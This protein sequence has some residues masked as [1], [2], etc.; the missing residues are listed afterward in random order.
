MVVHSFSLDVSKPGSQ[1]VIYATRGDVG[2]RRLVM[3]L[4]EDGAPVSLSAASSVVLRVAKPDDTF[5]LADCD[6]VDAEGG[7]VDHVLEASTLAALGRAA[8]QLTVYGVDSDVLFSP[9][10]EIFVQ[11]SVYDDAVAESSDD[12]SALTAALTEATALT[13]AWSNPSATAQLIV[14][15]SARWLVRLAS[16]QH[17]TARTASTAKSTGAAGVQ[18]NSPAPKLSEE[19]SVLCSMV[20][21]PFK[22][23]IRPVRVKVIP[24]N[25]TANAAIPPVNGTKK[26]LASVRRYSHSTTSTRYPSVRKGQQSTAP[27]K[28]TPAATVC[29]VRWRRM[30]TRMVPA[31][32]RNRMPREL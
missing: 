5:V 27:A 25:T 12:F 2:A 11:P 24:R 31:S 29:A 17:T 22:K 3:R 15:Y 21:S 16:R 1:G 18:K 20:F 14:R 32:T 10:F 6:V 23:R 19:R 13:A 30:V 28:S 4:V 7:V 9:A 26:A 8:C